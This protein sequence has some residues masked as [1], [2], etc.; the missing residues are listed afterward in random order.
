MATVAAVEMSLKK[1]GHGFEFGAGLKA[2]E[3]ELSRL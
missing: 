1:L 3:Q 2:A